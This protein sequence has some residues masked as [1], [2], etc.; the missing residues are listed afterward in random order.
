[1]LHGDICSLCNAPPFTQ[2]RPAGPA[3]P[4][5]HSISLTGHSERAPS[6]P[7]RK[8][9]TNTICY[10][11]LSQAGEPL[12]GELF[13]IISSAARSLIVSVFCTRVS[14]SVLQAVCAAFRRELHHT[15]TTSPQRPPKVTGWL[16]VRVFLG[17]LPHCSVSPFFFVWCGLVAKA[18][19]TPDS[20]SPR[21]RFV[22]MV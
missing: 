8:R 21:L 9:N 12:H 10:I 22:E 5:H 15:T 11:H 6:L 16:K 20:N 13:A 19:A 3:Q 17:S 4:T 14:R 1:M 18:F 2:H 7:P